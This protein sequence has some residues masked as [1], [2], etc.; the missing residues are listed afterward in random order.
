MRK[1]MIVSAVTILLLVFCAPVSG[2]TCESLRSL[3]LPNITVTAAETLDAGLFTGPQTPFGQSVPLFLPKRCRVTAVAAPSADSH[4]EME[5]WMPL[6]AWNGKFEAVGNGGW[7]GVITYGGVP[8]GIA[9]NMAAA[10]IDGYATSSTDT[11]HRNDGTA[12]RFAVGHPEKLIDFAY[13]AVHEMTMASKALIT[14]FYGSAPKLSYWNGCST[15]GRQGLLEAQRYPDDFDGIVA[16]AP[17]NNW[18]HLMIGIVSASQAAHKG[19]PGNLPKEKLKLL[20]DSVVAACDRLMAS[21]MASFRTRGAAR[22]MR[23]TC[24]ARVRSNLVYG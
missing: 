16:G 6:E 9:R 19:Q 21:V 20:H 10:L 4:I 5:L 13:R 15:G 12:G 23:I 18:T 24:F 8:Q 3:S 22:S 11:G 17:A 2:A 7:A 1:P 14:A